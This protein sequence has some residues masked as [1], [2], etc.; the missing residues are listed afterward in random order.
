MLSLWLMGAVLWDKEN[1]QFNLNS[2][3]RPPDLTGVG[4]RGLF[5]LS[6]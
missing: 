2:V 3:H 5:T 4:L 6:S 1:R